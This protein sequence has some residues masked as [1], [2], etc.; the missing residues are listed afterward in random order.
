[1]TYYFNKVYI[2]QKYSLLSSGK[3]NPI[4]KGNTEYID[5]KIDENIMNVLLFTSGTTSQSKAVMLSQKNIAANIY[6]MQCVEDIRCTDTN[7]AFLP[8]HH[9]F[10]STCMMVMLLLLRRIRGVSLIVPILNCL[11]MGVIACVRVF[12]KFSTLVIN[13]LVIMRFQDFM[14]IM[15]TQSL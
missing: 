11:L 4:V 14:A 1:M 10:G 5:A 15:L 13:R 8:F 3:Y 12:L 9:I 6:A 2:N 7:I